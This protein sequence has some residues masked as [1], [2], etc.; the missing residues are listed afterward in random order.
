MV[1]RMVDRLGGRLVDPMVDLMVDWT[2]GH[3]VDQLEAGRMAVL[4]QV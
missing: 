2:E 3:W 1:D 4:V